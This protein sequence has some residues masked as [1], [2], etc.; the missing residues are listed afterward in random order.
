M[1]TS[2]T[3]PPIISSVSQLFALYLADA[4]RRNKVSWPD[5]EGRF[6]K[7]LLPT[8]G[9]LH[10][11]EVTPDHI[12]SCLPYQLAPATRL[13]VVAVVRGLFNWAKRR[14][15]FKGQ[16]PT[17]GVERER[18]D[19]RRT[20]YLGTKE[21]RRLLDVLDSKAQTRFRLV[22][23]AI[24]FSGRRRGELLDLEWSDVNFEAGLVTYRHTK[25]RRNQ[26]L[27]DYQSHFLTLQFLVYD[28]L[29]PN[30][31]QLKQVFLGDLGAMP[32]NI[33]R[34]HHLKNPVRLLS[35]C[36]EVNS[37][38]QACQEGLDIQSLLRT[39][40]DL[41]NLTLSVFLNANVLDEL[42]C[43]VINFKVPVLVENQRG[44]DEVGDLLY[45]FGVSEL[46][47][48]LLVDEGVEAKKYPQ[49]CPHKREKSEPNSY[50]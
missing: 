41:L 47:G 6:R 13:Q 26:T 5:D 3:T 18:F 48:D 25:N 37:S 35:G 44:S 7:H 29:S 33:V 17:E 38:V 9:H 49:S 46:E 39:H 28:G 34:P 23:K 2:V 22:V 36:G 10:P 16:N 43:A 42:G 24:L 19:N 15:L 4:M 50:N 12:V 40:N 20:T 27:C 1:K 14:R 8:I 21:V 45:D 32:R 31:L 11:S 30:D